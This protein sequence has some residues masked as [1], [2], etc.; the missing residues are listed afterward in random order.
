MLDIIK[1]A[2]K[3]LC[4]HVEVRDIRTGSLTLQTIIDV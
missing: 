4:I 1:K 3:S 2:E